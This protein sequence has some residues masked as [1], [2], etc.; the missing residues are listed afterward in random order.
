LIKPALHILL[1]PDREEDKV[2]ILLKNKGFAEKFEKL[3]ELYSLPKVIKNWILH[4]FLHPFMHCFLVFA[5]VMQVM[6]I[7]RCWSPFCQGKVPKE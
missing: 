7:D 2:P 3:G 5:L 1:K 6:D 4:L